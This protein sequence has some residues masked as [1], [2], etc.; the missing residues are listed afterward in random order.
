[1]RQVREL[2]SELT[3]RGATLYD[4]LAKELVNKDTRTMQSSR[5]LEI[6]NVEKVLKQAISSAE[7]KLESAKSVLEN[8]KVELQTLDSK[9]QRKSSELDRSKQRL[10]ALQKV[11]P[12]YL[13]EFERLEVELKGLY[14]QY[15]VRIRCMDALKFQMA[16][17]NRTPTPSSALGKIAESSMTIL[18]EGLMDSDDEDDEDDND[19]DENLK[20]E[21]KSLRDELLHT[22]HPRSNTRINRVRTAGRGGMRL[23][24]SMSG[25]HQPDIDNLDSSLGSDDSG[26]EIDLGDEVGCEL[27]QFLFFTIFIQIHFFIVFPYS[28]G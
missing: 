22:N 16:L 14:E 19:N 5:P 8:S 18:P 26:S 24:G 23:R 28:N 27:K 9:L 17:K 15:I 6:A 10:Q 4:L 12:A 2:S 3:N 20:V 25:S 7:S 13:D 11:R 1:M 21:S